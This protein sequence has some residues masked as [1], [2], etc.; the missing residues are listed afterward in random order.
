MSSELASQ[1]SIDGNEEG[2]IISQARPPPQEEESTTSIV[3]GDHDGGPSTHSDRVMSFLNP[4][5]TESTDPEAIEDQL[6][7]MASSPRGS[8]NNT[9]ASSP[10][11]V[12]TH[13]SPTHHTHKEETNSIS[14]HIRHFAGLAQTTIPPNSSTLSVSQRGESTTMSAL[15]YSVAEGDPSNTL[16]GQYSNERAENGDDDVGPPTSIIQQPDD[17][18]YESSSNLINLDSMKEGSEHVSEVS[19]FHV[20]EANEGNDAAAGGINNNNN[21]NQTS[22]LNID[23]SSGSS[24][25][26]QG[27]YADQVPALSGS[28]SASNNND[29]GMGN[30]TTQ[31]QHHPH[32]MQEEIDLAQGHIIG[33]TRKEEGLMMMDDSVPISNADSGDTSSSPKPMQSDLDDILGPKGEPVQSDL[34]DILGPQGEDGVPSNLD[35]TLGPYDGSKAPTTVSASEVVASATEESNNNYAALYTAQL[36]QQGGDRV[37]PSR[38]PPHLQIDPATQN[39]DSLSE[40]GTPT[41]HTT[42]ISRRAINNIGMALAQREVDNQSIYSPTNASA[43][44]LPEVSV[45]GGSTAFGTAM[46]YHPASPAVVQVLSSNSSMSMAQQRK[47]YDP[48]KAES[49]D[50]VEP[51]STWD[52][53]EKSSMWVASASQDATTQGDDDTTTQGGDTLS[54]DNQSSYWGSSRG[55]TM[56]PSASSRGHAMSPGASSQGDTLSPS[57]RTGHTFSPSARDSRLLSNV[58][59]SQDETYA[60]SYRNTFPDDSTRGY[61]IASPAESS[62]VGS[63]SPGSYSHGEQFSFT[64]HSRMNQ[65]TS[66][67]QSRTDQFS[68]ADSTSRGE[69]FDPD[70]AQ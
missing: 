45:A 56:S 54:P 53:K 15:S 58:A 41:N 57:S 51:A 28:T 32:I 38:P 63:V 60:S 35:D 33:Y 4:M 7:Q 30:Q 61:S 31:P 8:N 66:A 22:W 21:N 37:A 62:R 5:S 50:S 34:D 10:P 13:L 44:I 19:D 47:Q 70:R 55:E 14:D 23:S 40:G 18:G 3:T 27:S 20:V 39:S 2:K 48:R 9:A 43:S 42:S 29:D 65:C 67:E 26:S 46:D 69:A 64:D 12:V 24:M 68:P 16:L 1:S 17:D 11:I 52:S 25:G 6:L 59:S 49:I 36:H